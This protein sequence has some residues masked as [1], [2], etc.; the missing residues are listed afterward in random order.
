MK[1]WLMW[2]QSLMHLTGPALASNQ[3]HHI[4]IC[5]SL[6]IYKQMDVVSWLFVAWQFPKHHFD[7]HMIPIQ[8]I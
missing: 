2:Y 3:E 7:C 8:M 4:P 6:T 1:I 5:H